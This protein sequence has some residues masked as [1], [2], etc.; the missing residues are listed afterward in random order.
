MT[1]SQSAQRNTTE[2]TQKAVLGINAFIQPLIGPFAAVPASILSI[3]GK[4]TPPYSAV[5]HLNGHE[6]APPIPIDAVAAVIHFCDELNAETLADAYKRV[7]V[8]KQIP[9]SGHPGP[10]DGNIE[11]TSGFIVAGVSSMSLEEIDSEI[12]KLNQQHPSDEWPDAVAVLDKGIINYTALIPGRELP[13]DFFLPSKDSADRQ[14]APSVYIRRVIRATGALTLNKIA[15]LVMARAAIFRPGAK[16]PDYNGPIAGIYPHGL[17]T[18]TYQFNLAN[19]LVLATREQEIASRLPQRN[20]FIVSN[21][22]KLATI[23][24]LEWQDGGV[25]VLRGGFPI[26]VFWVFAKEVVPGLD[27][28]RASYFRNG[29]LQVSYVLPMNRLQFAMTLEIFQR[30][31]SNIS[32]LPDTTRHLVQKYSDEGTSSPFIARL[33]ITPVSLRDAALDEQR[34][35][36]FDQLY[37]QVLAGLRNAREAM[38][39]VVDHWV[40]HN[41][42]IV[43]GEIVRVSRDT[44]HIDESIDRQLRRE[45]EDFLITTTRVMK[46]PMQ[47]LMK[48]LGLDVGYLFQKQ[49]TFVGG[50]EKARQ[51]DPVLAAYIADVRQ[52]SEPLV[53]MRNDLEHS[54]I[55]APR[56]SYD[57][58]RGPVRANEPR[59]SDKPITEYVADVFDRVCC[60]VE[61]LTVYSLRKN[62]PECFEVS[63]L[64]IAD[65]EPSA[66]ERFRLTVFPGGRAPWV[67]TAHRRRFAEV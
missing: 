67:L 24:F 16:I 18:A 51:L 61:E 66:P 2:G 46:T 64:P 56:V 35:N 23:Q 20:Y 9:K 62:F 38:N 15:S 57:F 55:P 4:E 50:L 6:A 60:F 43:S 11:M 33:M 17:M 65:R 19:E 26:D 22:K 54:I 47:S 10:P 3:D 37:D 52:W 14:P 39:A 45:F 40:K 36:E 48:S 21:G 7:R 25:I 12:G 30:R 44:V 53:Q 42:K 49:S 59:V 58:E 13:G 29:D 32:V 27:M 63:E 28:D 41:A 31:G 1:D 8:A 5:V 34:R